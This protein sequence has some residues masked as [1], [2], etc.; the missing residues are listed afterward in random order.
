MCVCVCV[1]VRVRVRVSVSDVYLG[2]P[3][4][5]FPFT[6]RS[7]LSLRTLPSTLSPPFS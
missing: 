1:R 4:V 5:L 6:V 7:L 3:G 2:V